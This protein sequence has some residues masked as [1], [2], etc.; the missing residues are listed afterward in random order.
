[1]RIRD[2]SGSSHVRHAHW[3][4]IAVRCGILVG[5]DTFL[6]CMHAELARER[7]I[8]AAAVAAW[9]AHHEQ[10][11]AEARH[12]RRQGLQALETLRAECGARQEALEREAAEAR[13]SSGSRQRELASQ[14]AAELRRLQVRHAKEW[15]ACIPDAGR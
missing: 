3:T 7:E 5:D 9:Q 14:H 12:A 8:V 4:F 6:G 11:T 10:L 13:A 15:P 1:M 2:D